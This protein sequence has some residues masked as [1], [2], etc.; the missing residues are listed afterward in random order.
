VVHL[1]FVLSVERYIQMKRFLMRQW[2]EGKNVQQVH[3]AS[4]KQR[5]DVDLSLMGVPIQ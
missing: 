5:E 4:M 3:P 1:P 2:R